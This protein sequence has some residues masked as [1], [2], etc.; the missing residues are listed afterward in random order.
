MK[1]KK[2]FIG[3]ASL[4]AAVG[5]TSCSS[6]EMDNQNSKLQGGQIIRLTTSAS[7]MRAT[8]DPQAGT[9]LS[10][11]SD[12][13][14]FAMNGT[15]ALENGNNEQYTV[16]G[17]GNMSPITASHLMVWPGKALNF[18]AYAPYNSAYTYNGSN[19]FS[20]K[21][22]QSTEA[23]YLASDLVL[24]QAATAA[25]YDTSTPVALQFKHQMA[26]I[27]VTINKAAG[28]T[29]DLSKAKVSIINTQITTTF[30]PN[31]TNTGDDK[32]LG[33][34]SDD[35]TDIVIVSALGDA[36]SAVGIIVPQTIA[37]GKGLVKI[38]TNPGESD[39]RTLI[40]KLGEE[41]VFASGEQYSF[42]AVINDPEAPVT[43][44]TLKPGSENLVAWNDNN[45]G[46]STAEYN[47]GD[48]ICKDGS[49]LRS[50]EVTDEN[51]A[52][53]V[54][55]IFSN[56]VSSA[57]AE[58]GYDGYAVGLTMLTGKR[59][60]TNENDDT[61]KA[62]ITAGPSSEPATASTTLGNAI[63]LLNGLTLTESFQSHYSIT[64]S[65][66][67]G[68]SF[69]NLSNYEAVTGTNLSSWFIPSFGQVVTILNELGE[70]GIDDTKYDSASGDLSNNNAFCTTTGSGAKGD[71]AL[72]LTKLNNA[73]T[74]VKGE[75][76]F[77]SGFTWSTSTENGDKHWYAK[78]TSTG[79]ELG[80]SAPKY[81]QYSGT[82]RATIPCIAFKLQ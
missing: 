61:N 46:A 41:V 59:W 36:T 77:T 45:L 68:D 52:N 15:T 38:Q 47:I 51:K 72:L 37:A 25:D 12:L 3:L 67:Y 53:I 23:D 26:K 81:S 43:Y 22:N 32:V 54:A 71:N 27:N 44:I 75:N 56:Q 30:K 63:A 74:Q 62:V 19:S 66:T 21:T 55:V 16:D 60:L 80:R 79:F 33:E 65:E 42:T 29:V 39:N 35:A 14:V 17:S 13:A 58:A 78:I 28:A 49:L 64:S 8:N 9:A 82:S 73:F 5:F 70:A 50:S 4:V 31:A 34:A 18:Y 48:Y 7:T 10:T 57:D 6:D 1:Q 20:V 76:F 24:A 69:F 40:A 2:F 11:S